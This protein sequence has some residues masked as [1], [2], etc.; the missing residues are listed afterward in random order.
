MGIALVIGTTEYWIISVG[1]FTLLLL[2]RQKNLQALRVNRLILSLV[3]FFTVI[4]LY[5]PS[6]VKGIYYA[7]SIYICAVI[8]N[9]NPS[10]KHIIT[11]I[12]LVS[13][14]Q[15]AWGIIQYT[16]GMARISGVTQN[17][18]AMGI[19]S[20]SYLPHP[21]AVIVTGLSLSRTALAGI[22]CFAVLRNTKVVWGLFT[23]A[24]LIHLSV[25]L[26]LNP[27]YL[28]PSGLLNA[29]D[30]RPGVFTSLELRKDLI[31]GST[32]ETVPDVE[33][34]KRQLSLF[35]YGH[36]GYALSTGLFQP[37]NIYVLS[38]WESG[39]LAIIFWILVV[40]LW[41]R[42]RN[43]YMLILLPLG[44]LVD[45]WWTDVE[46][47][48]AV[49]LMHLM[50]RRMSYVRFDRLLRFDRIGVMAWGHKSV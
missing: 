2:Y 29:S 26:I 10:R 1:I 39:A 17:A 4:S 7:A 34:Q 24:I 28:T 35:G 15:I 6:P 36:H 31:N 47:V 32:A 25:N 11:T 49:T 33:I 5:S 9:S 20:L 45:E 41:W 16:Q 3:V 46:G 27:A 37:H 12:F 13:I 44:L 23:L 22:A 50:T 48:Y 18:S 40:A 30:R 43:P 42:V 38:V 21:L 19:M 8:I 14:T